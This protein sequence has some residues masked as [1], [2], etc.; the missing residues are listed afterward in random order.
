[1]I[2][3]PGYPKIVSVFSESKAS[4]TARLPVV[5]V[6][7]A[8][9]G[10][11]VGSSNVFTFCFCVIYFDKKKPFSVLDEKGLIVGT[12]ILTRQLERIIIIAIIIEV[13]F[14]MFGLNKKTSRFGRFDKLYIDY[15]FI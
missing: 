12:T 4:I 6:E 14:F 5:D 13:E 8:F 7:L 11:C 1:M 9:L 3:P 10:S 15:L 2:A